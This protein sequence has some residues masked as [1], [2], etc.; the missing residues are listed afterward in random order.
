MCA[1]LDRIYNVDVNYGNFN[2]NIHLNR[3]YNLLHC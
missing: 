3:N 2:N 1:I